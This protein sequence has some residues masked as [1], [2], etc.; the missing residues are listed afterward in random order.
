MNGIRQK[1]TGCYLMSQKVVLIATLDT[2]G[3]EIDYCREVVNELGYETIIIDTGILNTPFIPG[4]ITRQ[5]IAELGGENLQ[6]LL[7]RGDKGLAIETMTNGAKAAVTELYIKGNLGGVL[8]LGGGQGTYIGTSVMKVLPLG[9]PKVMVSTLVAGDIRRFVGTKDILMFNSVS[10]VLGLNVISRQLLRNAV[11][12]LIGMIPFAAAVKKSNRITVGMSMLGTTTVGAMIANS[13]LEK[14][15]L[16]VI[17]FHANGPGGEAIEEL[18]TAGFFDAMLEYSPHQLTAEICHGIFASGPDR[19]MAA[20]HRG[21][22][23]LIVPGGLDNIIQGPFELMPP[24]HKKRPYI[25]H[26]KNI[27]LVRTSKDEMIEVGRVLADKLNQASGP[28]KV[29]IP[30]QGFCEP[31]Q[32]GRK[33]YFPELDEAFITTLEKYIKP[34]VSVI[35][36]DAHINDQLFADRVVEEFF[37]LIQQA[38]LFKKIS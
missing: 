28:A 22:P 33:F 19:L 11:A 25:V 4:D 13:E 18:T 5:R 2:K 8:A 14:N 37:G 20:G 24:E 7:K 3:R 36:V 27:T 17:T 29:V 6:T 21:I 15:G 34:S 32:K 10:D 30:L 12:A 23:Q 1:I 26:N 35:K 16:E 38:G 9:I 31:N